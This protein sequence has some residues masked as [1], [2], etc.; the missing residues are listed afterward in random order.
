MKKKNHFVVMLMLIAMLLVAA[1]CQSPHSTTDDASQQQNNAG[2]NAFNSVSGNSTS[3][4][5]L[6]AGTYSAKKFIAQPVDE[7]LIRQIL[8]SGAKAP[9]ARNLQPWHFTVVKDFDMVSKLAGQAAEG[10][11]AIIVSG[12]TEEQPGVNA[13]FDCGLA[14]QNMYLAAQSL[15]LGA[16]L[17]AGPVSHVNAQYREN[18]GI[19]DGYDAEI[20]L[21]VGYVDPEVDA[22]SSAS[23]RNP[24][25]DMVNYVE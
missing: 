24:L 17:Y 2:E 18:L 13:I 10:C 15:G 19:P 9:S 1:G 22:V 14:T 8:E 11:V 7:E 5:D 16:H 3:L 20:I 21:C 23:V 4:I 25:A 12:L 6:I